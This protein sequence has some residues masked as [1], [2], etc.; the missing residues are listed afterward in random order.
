MGLGSGLDL[1]PE[2]SGPPGAL[3]AAASSAYG[4]RLPPLADADG[5]AIA[6]REDGG[7]SRVNQVDGWRQSG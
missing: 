3:Q 5:V 6:D 7:V 4:Q 2:R 1:Q